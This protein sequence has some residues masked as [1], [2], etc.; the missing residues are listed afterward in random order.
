[1]EIKTM[2]DIRYKYSLGVTAII[3]NEALY[4]EEWLDYHIVA[5]VDIF[6]LFDDDSSDNT[7][8][9]LKP[10]INE[11][12][13]ELIQLGKQPNTD[14]Y[15]T[16]TLVY[17]LSLITHKYDVKYM[18]F[19]DIDEF[20]L[21]YIGTDIYSAVECIL[22]DLPYACGIA[23]NWR[24]FGSSGHI[25]HQESVLDNYLYRTRDCYGANGL[26][27]SI[28]NPRFVLGWYKNPHLCSC[29]PGY[30][31]VDENGKRITKVCGK[32]TFGKKIRINHYFCKSKEDW[33]KK[34]SRGL[35]DRPRDKYPRC[36]EEFDECSKDNIYD[37][38]ILLFIEEI[39]DGKKG[40]LNRQRI[41]SKYV[42]VP[43]DIREYSS[44]S[45]LLKYDIELLKKFF[46]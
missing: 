29:V 32:N 35:P 37:N 13:V 5:G 42:S 12:V 25:K 10:Y 45:I 43:Q 39:V 16:Q 7:L 2:H 6:Y 28:V 34:M 44:I 15:N 18:A 22:K 14:F 3:R 33:L 36:D 23:V 27:K 1:M 26:V 8:D 19:I 30:Y 24:I 9:V 4:L 40:R 38:D 21:P 46:I 20:I 11:G 31:I 17:N 41:N